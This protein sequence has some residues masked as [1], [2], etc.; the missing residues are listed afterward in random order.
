GRSGDITA[1]FLISPFKIGTVVEHRDT[2][3]HELNVTELLGGNRRD[4]AVKWLQLGLAAEIEALEQVVTESGHL[5]I[6]AA[7]QLLKS[8]ARVGIGCQGWRDF[9]LQFVDT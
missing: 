7:E 6:L 4:Q 5:A 2:V 8:G 3:A 9:Y 1:V